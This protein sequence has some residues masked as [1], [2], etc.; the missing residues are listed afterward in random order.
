MQPLD[1]RTPGAA[2]HPELR[3]GD[4]LDAIDVVVV[5]RVLTA[6]KSDTPIPPAVRTPTARGVATVVYPHSEGDPTL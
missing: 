4:P 2:M 1:Q 3:D 5:E 6:L